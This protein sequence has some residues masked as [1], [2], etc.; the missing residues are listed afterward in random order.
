PLQSVRLGGKIRLSGSFGVFLAGHLVAHFYNE[1][2]S[3]LGTIA[4]ANVTPA[5]PV[6]LETEVDPPGKPARVSLHVEDDHGVD[7]GSLQ[8]VQVGGGD[9]R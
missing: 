5:E 7:W 6:V 9:N 1:H 3:S 4:I 2:G 8:E